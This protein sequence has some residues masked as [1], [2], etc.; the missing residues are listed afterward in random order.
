MVA[1]HKISITATR[2]SNSSLGRVERPLS[3]VVQV[4][5]ALRQ[6]IE[7]DRF[8]DG[9]LPPEV[10]LA[11]Q[12]GVGR[13][14][15]RLAAEVLQREGLLFKVR[16]RGTFTRPPQ[17]PGQIKPVESKRL[18]YLQ[19][20]FLGAQGMEEVANRAISGMMLQGALA[21]AGLAGFSLEV[22]H[23]PHT[24]W[25]EAVSSLIENSRLRGLILASYAEEKMLRR[26]TA[27]DLPIVLL[28]EDV[29]VPHIH[30]V[31]DD[32]FEGARMA[33][34]H[35]AELGHRHIAYAHWQRDDQNRWRPM[36]FQRGLQDVGLPHRKQNEILTELTEAGAKKL[37]DRFLKLSVR[38]TA[39]YC[40]NNTLA[41]FAIAELQRRSV[42]VPNDV[43]IVGAGGEETPGL[44][45]HQVDW[46]SMGRTAVQIMLRAIANLEQ[47]KPEHYLSPHT[48]RLGKTTKRL[49]NKA[50]GSSGVS[51]KSC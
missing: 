2:Q 28:D 47:H 23:T 48:L 44:T 18:G 17:T 6:A 41:N 25:R 22:H 30:S 38:P 36:G 40:F 21:E 13:E 37:I 49:V 42:L 33:V 4:E 35:L 3:L 32:C 39:L 7:D 12:L 1:K 5:Q 14:T 27:R 26:L 24:R 43:S 10:E 50:I 11:E 45:C 19:T 51:L 46:Y 20:D 9:K 34:L 16:R 31:R 15:V 29:N 8:P